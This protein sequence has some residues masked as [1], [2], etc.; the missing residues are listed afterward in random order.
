MGGTDGAADTSHLLTRKKNNLS[1]L[2]QRVFAV[3]KNGL[4]Y[5]NNGVNYD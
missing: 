4:L 5:V 3:R 2:R 1:I